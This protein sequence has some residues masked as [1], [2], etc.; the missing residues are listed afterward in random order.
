MAMTG[1]GRSRRVAK[2]GPR[3]HERRRW[4][5]AFGADPLLLAEAVV[6]R[7][8]RLAHHDREVGIVEVSTQVR[9]EVHEIRRIRVDATVDVRVVPTLEPDEAGELR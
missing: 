3:R 6:P 2:K 7:V 4:R 5:D 9:R 8:A 1:V